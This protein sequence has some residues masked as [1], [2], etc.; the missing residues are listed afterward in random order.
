MY[1]QLL[2]NSYSP[3]IVKETFCEACENAQWVQGARVKYAKAE[4][5]Y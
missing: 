4:A 3:F 2:S 1:S 5:H